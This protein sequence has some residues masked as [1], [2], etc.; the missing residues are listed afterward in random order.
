M[1]KPEERKKRRRRAYASFYRG[2][3]IDPAPDK[4][5]SLSA[6]LKVDPVF[7]EPRLGGGNLEENVDRADIIRVEPLIHSSQPE[8]HAS[9]DDY[10]GRTKL[11]SAEHLARH[12]GQ[13]LDLGDRHFGF[14]SSGVE[15]L[16]IAASRQRS[17]LGK[18]G[19]ELSIAD[20]S[21]RPGV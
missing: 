4:Y 18:M 1:V 20:S 11:A 16:R 21:T 14:S 6:F 17:R 15:Q 7:C 19:S 8:E 10:S 5:D 2:S 12:I 9:R 13:A 3:K